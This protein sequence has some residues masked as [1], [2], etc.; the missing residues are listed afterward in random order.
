MILLLLPLFFNYQYHTCHFL[1]AQDPDCSV[2]SSSL[3]E[4]NGLCLFMITII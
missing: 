3:P 2:T 4:V 1:V